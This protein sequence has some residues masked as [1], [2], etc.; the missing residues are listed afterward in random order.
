M[1]AYFQLPEVY[2][3]CLR[4]EAS[5]E[6]LRRTLHLERARKAWEEPRPRGSAPQQR[7]QLEVAEPAPPS[8]S[9]RELG[10]NDGEEPSPPS[11]AA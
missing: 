11:L 2:Y 10:R 4:N 6:E 9:L 3:P 7:E 8:P 1:T 5:M